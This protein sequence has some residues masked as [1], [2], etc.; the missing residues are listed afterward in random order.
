[1]D[2][3][4]PVCTA[5][6]GIALR[7]S[8]HHKGSAFLPAKSSVSVAHVGVKINRIAGIQDV[9]IST[10]QKLQGPGKNVNKLKPLMHMRLGAAVTHRKKLREIWLEFA[11][12]RSKVQPC[13][14]VEIILPWLDNCGL[15]S[16][17]SPS[18]CNHA[19]A[20]F[21]LKEMVQRYLKYHRNA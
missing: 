13:K 18:D 9:F 15:F 4:Q 17:I 7:V 14:M 16:F 1:M 6:S 5:F 20:V 21:V 12:A 19:L 10:N 11:F 8:K 3:V 2:A